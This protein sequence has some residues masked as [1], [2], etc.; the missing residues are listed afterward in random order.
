MTCDCSLIRRELRCV[1]PAGKRTA[2]PERVVL[3]S[4]VGF[5]SGF[6]G[7]LLGCRCRVVFHPVSKRA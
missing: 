3:E 6:A 1:E 2:R 4:G 7:A 5:V